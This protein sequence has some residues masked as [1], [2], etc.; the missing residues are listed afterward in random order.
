M[1][2]TKLKGNDL[3]V[4]QDGNY[5]L[6]SCMD[7]HIVFSFAQ[8]GK[9]MTIHL[10][11]DK[12]GL[13]NIKPAINSFCQWLFDQYGW[14]NMILAVIANDLKSMMRIVKKCDFNYLTKNDNHSVYMR[15]RQ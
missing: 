12:I 9:A 10:A 8:K 3:G 7:N 11:S 2:F 13:R 1:N 5:R 4:Y 15:P 6:V 14:L